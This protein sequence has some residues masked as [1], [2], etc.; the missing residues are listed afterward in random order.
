M[1]SRVR[2][3]PP[4][5]NPTAFTFH[6]PVR[7]RLCGTNAQILSYVELKIRGHPL[8]HSMRSWRATRH[9]SCRPQTTASI[10]TAGCIA[11]LKR[12]YTRSSCCTIRRVQ[13]FTKA[14]RSNQAEQNRQFGAFLDKGSLMG[15]VLTIATRMIRHK[16]ELVLA[17]FFLLGA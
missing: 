13:P 8:R 5:S 2:H 4:A 3:D 9:S 12:L 7:S 14:K 6:S 11:T 10:A 17:T 1:V 16:E 15:D